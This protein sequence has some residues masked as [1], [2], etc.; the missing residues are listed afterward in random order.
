MI[1]K[2]NLTTKDLVAQVLSALDSIVTELSLYIIHVIY[3]LTKSLP[4]IYIVI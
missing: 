4:R 2:V 3:T 1:K